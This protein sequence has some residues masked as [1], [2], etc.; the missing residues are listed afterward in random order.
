MRVK[1]PHKLSTNV[2]LIIIFSFVLPVLLLVTLILT[3]TYREISL[4]TENSIK[5]SME[6]AISS[7]LIHM[8]SCVTASK[9]ASYL[10]TI[11]EIYEEYQK[12]HQ[13]D[14]LYESTNTF[15]DQQYK[16]DSRFSNVII[17][18]QEIPDRLYF[19]YHTQAGGSYQE[20]QYFEKN[21][22][23]DIADVAKDL[24]TDSY[25]LNKLGRVYLVRNIMSA[26]YFPYATIVMEINQ[27]EMIRSL[28]SIWGYEDCVVYEDGEYFFGNEDLYNLDAI[29]NN[30]SMNKVHFDYG[31]KL[32]W[33]SI[34]EDGH[35]FTYLVELSNKSIVDQT[36]LLGE[37]I[38]LAI[39]TI[40]VLALLIYELFKRKVSKPVKDLMN[41]AIEIGKGNYGYHVNT[42]FSIAEWGFLEEAFNSMSQ[43]LKYQFEK[44]YLEELALRDAEIKALQSQIN[45]HFLNNTL[46][47]INWEARLGKNYKVSK[48]IEA[49]STI[50]GA[51]MDRDDRHLVSLAE[52]M[53]YVDAY[54]YIIK[55]RLGERFQIH[56]DIEEECLQYEVPKLI[57]QPIIENAVEH[58]MVANQS[59][60]ITIRIY[61]RDEALLI[62]IISNGEMTETD[63]KKIKDLL[64]EDDLVEEAHSTRLGIRNVHKRLRILYGKPYGLTIKK[65]MPGGTSS[66]IMVKIDKN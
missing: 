3:F 12:N 53:S 30:I 44:I 43:K 32:I 58:G 64:S 61:R 13:E 45:P 55:K 42:D 4:K 40:T 48:M 57:I 59:K 29:Q 31:R 37:I 50:L 27:E 38:L 6:D 26:S 51:T 63:E 49:L 7:S 17:Y 23:E 52:E 54:L 14:E 36:A 25:F 2:L 18:Y 39:F 22:K 5:I 8:Q 16:F 24:G 19:T 65:Y 33:M 41:G 1:K 35:V 28:E 11:R 46:E 21:I 66:I 62:E 34:K 9:T 47:I 10:P 15:L 20:I 56:K 60:E